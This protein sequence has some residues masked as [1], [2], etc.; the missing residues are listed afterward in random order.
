M[1]NCFANH[2]IASPD[3]GTTLWNLGISWPHIEHF[4]PMGNEFEL[5]R[6]SSSVLWDMVTLFPCLNSDKTHTLT[7]PEQRKAAGEISDAQRI[8]N[9][10]EQAMPRQRANKRRA[11]G[12]RPIRRKT[13]YAILVHMYVDRTSSNPRRGFEMH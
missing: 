1:Q 9:L 5:Y 4:A 3:V 13:E 10:L 12:S 2:K 7:F 8:S 6:N 11:Q